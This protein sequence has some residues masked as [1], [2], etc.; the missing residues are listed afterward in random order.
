[1][2]A[3][4]IVTAEERRWF[5]SGDVMVRGNVFY[6]GRYLG[7]DIEHLFDDVT[8]P[9]TFRE[10]VNDLNGQFAVLV[11]ATDA[12]YAAVDHIASIPLF[13]GI[14]EG[15]VFVGDD[16][17]RMRESLPSEP[18]DEDAVT[19]FL[20]TGY[21]T[22]NDTLY[23]QIKQLQ[24]GQMLSVDRTASGGSSVRQYYSFT[25]Q[26]I[27]HERRQPLLERFDTV[28]KNAFERLGKRA[29]GDP[30]ILALSGGYDSRLAAFMIHR[31][32]YENVY[33]FTFPDFVTEGDVEIAGEVASR[34]GFEWAPVE[35]SE[36]D[37]REFFQS[38]EY[39][40]LQQTIE[41][42]V[43]VSPLLL[44]MLVL[45][46]L[47]ESSAFPDSGVVVTG[48]DVAGSARDLPPL[49]DDSGALDADAVVDWLWNKHYRM[50]HID[51]AGIRASMEDRIR[52]RL[53]PVD[54][55]D[56]TTGMDAIIRW[57]WQERTP[58]FLARHVSEYQQWGYDR[59]LPLWDRELADFWSSVPLEYRREKTLYEEHIERLDEGISGDPYPIAGEDTS[60]DLM[61]NVVSALETAVTNFPFE[62]AIREAFRKW[63]TR[64]VK[65]SMIH[66]RFAFL[67]PAQFEKLHPKI[68]HVKYFHALNKLSRIG[69]YPPRNSPFYDDIRLYE[70]L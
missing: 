57:Y 53:P 16:P 11:D 55:K 43:T 70:S 15:T 68:Q 9:V 67:S 52:S 4:E 10:R 13:Y 39:A 38:D 3:I 2:V 32:G 35:L 27:I 20:L 54:G 48:H 24:P 25:D 44:W 5:S 46:N 59:W 58:K 69:C 51:D 50:R 26:E 8:D 65:N 14:D 22:G 45:K 1:M 7:A 60:T 21:V 19:E 31:M 36:R 42:Y 62:S 6:E 33:A 40:Y 30:I 63:Q 17:I 61:K 49:D 12:V 47:K 41:D 18:C 28:L 66:A 34:L 23:P 37:F 64:S 56:P 29:D